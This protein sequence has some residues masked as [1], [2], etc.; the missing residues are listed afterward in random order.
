MRMKYKCDLKET[1]AER[2]SSVQWDAFPYLSVRS[3]RYQDYFT[4]K[5][6][7]TQ[8]CMFFFPLS[9]NQKSQLSTG[10]IC[11]Q[12]EKFRGLFKKDFVSLYVLYICH[13][14]TLQSQTG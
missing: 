3:E 2:T 1:R 10:V 6:F 9:S 8:L 5:C 14:R 12:D 13:V 11:P 4:L 7:R